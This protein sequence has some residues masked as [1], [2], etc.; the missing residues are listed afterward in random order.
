MTSDDI[1]IYIMIFQTVI[2]VISLFKKI[3]KCKN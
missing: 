2:M 1:M 3:K